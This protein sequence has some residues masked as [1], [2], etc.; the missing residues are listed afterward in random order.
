MASRLSLSLAASLLALWACAQA[1]QKAADRPKNLQV[2]ARDTPMAVVQAEM[3]D[4][5]QGL[6]VECSF[7]HVPGAYEKDDVD[8]K[9]VARRMMRMVNAMN[10]GYFSGRAEISCYTCHRGQRLPLRHAPRGGQ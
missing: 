10:D 4:V 6:G 7:C 3:K 9:R 1:P 2:L 5:A 8:M